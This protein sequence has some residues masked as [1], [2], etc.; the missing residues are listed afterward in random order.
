[1][2]FWTFLKLCALIYLDYNATTPCDPEVLDRMT[3]YFTSDFANPSSE[4]APGWMAREAIT[5]STIQTARILGIDPS[6]ITY[7]SGATE[8]INMVLKSLFFSDSRK[9]NQMVTAKTEHKAI[10]DTCQWL[11][12]QGATITYLDV[13]AQG[14]IKLEQ[15][16]AVLTKDTFLVSI[17][18]ANNETGTIQPM[19]RISEICANHGVPLFSDATQ[20]PG[21]ID[22]TNFFSQVDFACFSAHKFYGPKGIGFTYCNKN[23]K[24]KLDSFIQ[25]GG[26]QNGM[27][28]GTLN[29]PMIIGLAEAL[30]YSMEDFK[31]LYNRMSALRDR[32]ESGLLAIEDAYLNSSAEERLPN[33]TNIAFDYV[34]GEKLLRA[35]STKIAVSNGSACNSASVDPSHVLTAMGI[36]PGLAFASL[37][38]GVGRYTTEKDIDMAVALIR[39][40]VDILRQENILWE[41]RSTT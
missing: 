2:S 36:R 23:S 24:I 9:G 11:V 8:S 3:P 35:L 37:R 26:Q 16:E 41:R 31:N 25:G 30:K 1:M 21:K 17:M 34:D 15:L 19:E 28:G 18:L 22:L 29:T 4:H 12:R 6:E 38:I 40:E 32:L 14:L 10:L 13:D 33:T 20:A 39:D 27:R 5:K 7:T